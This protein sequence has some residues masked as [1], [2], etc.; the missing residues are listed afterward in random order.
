MFASSLISNVM[1]D[2]AAAAIFTPIAIGFALSLHT[3]PLP[4]VLA[5]AYGVKDAIAS[6]L[7]VA[8][9]TMLQPTGYRF[10]DYVVVGGSIN[11]IMLVV[12]AIMLKIVYFM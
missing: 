10:K 1:S 2:N 4:F 8:T 6:P 5:A 3:N 9:M 12:S 7:S 11:L